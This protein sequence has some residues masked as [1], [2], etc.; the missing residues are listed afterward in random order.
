MNILSAEFLILCAASAVFLWVFSRFQRKLPVLL[1]N[2][3][4]L[5]FLRARPQELAY[6]AALIIS[7]WLAAKLIKAWPGKRWPLVLS[8]SVPAAVLLLFK[9]AGF[10]LPHAGIMMPL[11][12]SFYTFRAISYIAECA[13]GEC[14]VKDLIAVADY[15]AFFP[16]FQA[17]PINR[18]QP[19]FKQL[20]TPF[21]FDYR[22]Q[23]NGFI[24]AVL[25]LFQ[26]LV[27][28][29]Q[30][31]HLTGAFLN[32]KLS[33][34]YTLL[35]VILY[36]FQIYVDFDAYSN[37]A[38]GTARLLGFRISRNFHTPYL[39]VSLRDFWNRWHI[40]L[41]SWL[42]DY[43]YI[44]L[45]GGR[46]GL[47]RKYLNTLAVFFV[48]GI[49]HGSGMMFIVWGLGHGVL[50]VLED[51]LRQK[52]GVKPWM[53]WF[54]PIAVL[55]NF[56][57]V[58]F[59]W[60]F[61]RSPDAAEAGRIIASLGSVQL[62]ASAAELAETAGITYNELLWAGVLVLMVFISD[63]MRYKTDMLEFLANRS[64]PVRWAFYLALMIIA[65]IFGVYGP[66]YHPEDFIYVTF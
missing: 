23:K 21:E 62:P 38:V 57:V 29:D 19:F 22:D 5:Y 66:G 36:A 8:V 4:F 12:L 2:L 60:I 14:E 10:V 47:V 49:W 25:G 34:I 45:G 44:P 20:E 15:I 54:A 48:S 31:S 51:I 43:I 56:A 28:A 40:S 64:F 32:V 13:K 41:S 1:C 55:F 7:T 24:Q 16:V 11:G 33:G 65:V 52:V 26:K 17:G 37:V 59:L 42:R 61:F 3:A 6:L 53:K 39:A 63:L 30:L 27:I 50:N 58:A 18:P 9:Y 35:G 46:K